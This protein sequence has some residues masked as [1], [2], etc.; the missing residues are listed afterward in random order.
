MPRRKDHCKRMLHTW[1]WGD[2]A[3][4]R[5][6]GTVARQSLPMGLLLAAPSDLGRRAGALWGA[7]GPPQVQV[8]SEDSVGGSSARSGLPSS[9]HRVPQPGSLVSGTRG[10][11]H[12]FPELG[13]E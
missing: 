11:S 12:I 4:C 10:S 9:P 13:W 2:K 6:L 8:Q 5:H 1:K 7:S 3:V